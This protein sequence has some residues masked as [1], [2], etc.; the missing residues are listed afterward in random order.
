ME[1]NS[2][3]I[4]TQ[5]SPHKI[6]EI[7]QSTKRSEAAAAVAAAAAKKSSDFCELPIADHGT[8]QFVVGSR[9]T[10]LITDVT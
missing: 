8:S 2:Y 4:Y 9:K 3:S 7:G 5:T 10:S 6:K 1:Q